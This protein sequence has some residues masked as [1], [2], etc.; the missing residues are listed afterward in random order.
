MGFL[1]NV[2]IV[3]SEIISIFAN[4]KGKEYIFQNSLNNFEGIMDLYSPLYVSYGGFMICTKGS[5][6]TLINS[7]QYILKQW[8]LVVA[9]PYSLIQLIGKSEDFESVL[10]GVNIDFFVKL[11]IPNRMDYYALVK[12][13]PS[14]SLM[15]EDAK[16][17]IALKELLIPEE[18][19]GNEP[20]NKYINDSILRIIFYKG[21]NIYSSSK[22]NSAKKNSRDEII[23]YTFIT[24]MFNNFKRERNLTFYAQRQLLTASHLS[25]AVKRASGRN[26]STWLIDFVISN[27]KNSLLANTLSIYEIADE[28]NFASNSIF[29][30]YFKKYTGETPTEFRRR[31][32]G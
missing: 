13:N 22:P 31:S 9:L 18:E 23:L 10:I 30:Q 32:K 12:N 3:I 29:C 6:T 25:R 27:I 7:K 24:D 28:Y 14:I 1:L 26:A 21:L 4:M 19:E 16:K 11:Q 17:I 5:C 15:E 20:F 8:D 2:G